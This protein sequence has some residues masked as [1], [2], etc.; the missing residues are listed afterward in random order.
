MS[1]ARIT[2]ELLR[3][4]RIRG[5]MYS[6]GHKVNLTRLAGD[7]LIRQSIARAVTAPA[8]KPSE[9]PARS[10]DST[11]APEADP[12]GWAE[13][14][15]MSHTDARAHVEALAGTASPQGWVPLKAHFAAYLAGDLTE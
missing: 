14:R 15:A 9:P 11:P 12:E 7:S 8:P 13:I 5:A 2:V 10:T 1:K 3:P 6:K 4:T